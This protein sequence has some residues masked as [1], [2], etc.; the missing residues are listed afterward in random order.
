MDIGYVR[1]TLWP[2]SNYIYPDKLN[3]VLCLSYV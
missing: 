3:L 1:L 2:P